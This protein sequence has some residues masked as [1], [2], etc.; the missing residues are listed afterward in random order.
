MSPKARDRDE[1][2]LTEREVVHQ[3]APHFR[4]MARRYEKAGL[5][6]GVTIAALIAAGFN[7]AQEEFGVAA[8]REWIECMR[9]AFA[10]AEDGKLF[11]VAQRA[12]CARS[13][14]SSLV[15][16]PFHLARI[17]AR[18]NSALTPNCRRTLTTPRPR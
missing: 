1:T 7:A 17:M 4:E 13:A 2:Y 16:C 9:V 5:P 18:S 6:I 14:R 12:D 10:E 15:C 11:E 8:V 3:L